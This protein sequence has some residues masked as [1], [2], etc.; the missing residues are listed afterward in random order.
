MAVEIHGLKEL[1]ARMRKIP[2]ELQKGAQS[3]VR[4]GLL[5]AG[6]VL[7]DQAKQLAPV[8]T[9]QL[10]NSIKNLKRPK[11]L[12]RGNMNPARY[13]VAKGQEHVAQFVEFGTG[14]FF[15]GSADRVR[16]KKKKILF[17]RAENE[18]YGASAQG[19]APQPFLR[20]AL[21]RGH[22]PAVEAFRKGM[23]SKLNT[24]ERKFGNR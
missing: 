16:P 19:Q 12:S 4:F 9:G 5:K 1:Q 22:R 24:L 8:R 6:N 2:A 18:I 14:A 11:R 21:E 3:P 7:R 13:I 15:A 23:A 10:R 20:P 17:N